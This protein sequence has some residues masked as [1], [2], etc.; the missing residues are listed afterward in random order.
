[1]YWF[2]PSEVKQSGKGPGQVLQA[3]AGEAHDVDEE[4]VVVAAVVVARRQVDRDLTR[5]RVTEEIAA[6]GRRLDRDAGEAPSRLTEV[7]SRHAA[8]LVPGVPG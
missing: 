5:R 4:G 7:V 3:A 8:I 2:P 6:Q 1:M